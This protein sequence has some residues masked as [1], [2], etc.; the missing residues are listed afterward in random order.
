M[1]LPADLLT[2]VDGAGKLQGRTRSAVFQE[3]LRAWLGRHETASLVGEYEAGY[4]RNPE[5]ESDVAAA[6]ASAVL[7]LAEEKW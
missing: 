7:L 4:R 1:S 2:A 3:A 6:E 5:D